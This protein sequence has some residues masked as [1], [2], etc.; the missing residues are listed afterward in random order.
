MDLSLLINAL[1]AQ[2]AQPIVTQGTPAQAI[3]AQE[4]L[5]QATEPTEV[6]FNV[7]GNIQ[8]EFL[9]MTK[10]EDES[11]ALTKFISQVTKNAAV[12]EILYQPE[13][14]A[15]KYTILYYSALFAAAAEVLFQPEFVHIVLLHR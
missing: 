5:A 4:T 11:A 12:M 6:N 14:I 15:K 2:L 7:A 8:L 13:E 10:M 9:I 1:Q 3:I